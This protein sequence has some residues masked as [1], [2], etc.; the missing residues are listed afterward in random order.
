MLGQAGG[1]PHRPPEQ[2]SEQRHFEDLSG[3][4]SLTEDALVSETIT[5]MSSPFHG[6][7][8][9]F[10]MVHLGESYLGHIT[11]GLGS[12]LP[13][14]Q[15]GVKGNGIGSDGICETGTDGL[16]SS[17][18]THSSAG[19]K[20]L[21]CDKDSLPQPR[22][23]TGSGIIPSLASGTSDRMLGADGED[24]AAE[25][26]IRKSKRRTEYQTAYKAKKRFEERSK[27]FEVKKQERQVYIDRLY[28]ILDKDAYEDLIIWD[29]PAPGL[30]AMPSS[31]SMPVS[32]LP[33]QVPLLNPE[34]TPVGSNSGM[35][36]PSAMPFSVVPST[37]NLPMYGDLGR[38][39]EPTTHSGTGGGKRQPGKGKTCKLSRHSM[40]HIHRRCMA[41]Y[42]YFKRL[43][44]V[45]VSSR[46]TA[47]MEE[48]AASL[49]PRVHLRTLR[50]WEK[51]F[52]TNGMMFK[53]PT[54]GK[55][56]RHTNNDETHLGSD[57]Q[58]DEGMEAGTEIA[59]LVPPP[60]TQLMGGV[61][62]PP[63]LKH[64]A[65]GVGGGGAW[66]NCDRRVGGMFDR[67]PAKDMSRVEIEQRW[68]S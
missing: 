46:T 12:S 66:S 13:P 34:A 43:N 6:F 47:L 64:P 22:K 3:G 8:S 30:S 41:L 51:E 15:I 40:L 65:K 11:L 19:S 36:I 68:P 55:W 67:L 25:Q 2:G 45:G 44:E 4:L 10:P 56:E 49:V 61:T 31:T 24:G 58:Q 7:S 1:V 48:V 50:T 17:L 59:H 42:N 63:G 33:A 32:P 60:P 20:T 21:C 16:P 54:R 18:N 28:K 14:A 29:S 53:A 23:S 38:A 35:N 9:S 26:S 62:H 52:I 57:M 39:E 27:R 37:G 5:P